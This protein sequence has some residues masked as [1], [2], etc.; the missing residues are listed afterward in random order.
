L[1]LHSLIWGDNH[2]ASSHIPHIA[3]CFAS[4]ESCIDSV[5]PASFGSWS[6]L[7]YG[8]TSIESSPSGP[9]M[10]TVDMACVLEPLPFAEAAVTS[11]VTPCGTER[12]REPIFDL[13]GEVVVKALHA[14]A[15]AN[16]GRRK[17]G[18]ESD[19]CVEGRDAHCAHRRRA[20][21]NMVYILGTMV[22]LQISGDSLMQKFRTNGVFRD[23]P[24]RSRDSA[25]H[26]GSR[27]FPQPVLF[28]HR[29][30]TAAIVC[31]S[32]NLASTHCPSSLLP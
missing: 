9:L 7:M 27:G 15:L 3:F 19:C 16:A 14:G 32:T 26:L 29:K 28:A 11:K 30:L 2:V 23:E 17:V 1:Y 18:I 12:G 6:M 13:H 24:P 5:G 22:S 10:C 4:V 8:G 25:T 31:C 21:A 20:G